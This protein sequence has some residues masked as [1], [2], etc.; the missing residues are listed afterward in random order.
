LAAGVQGLSPV[1]AAAVMSE[2]PDWGCVPLPGDP[3]HGTITIGGVQYPCEVLNVTGVAPQRILG[4]PSQ[5]GRRSRD[6][7]RFPARGLHGSTHKNRSSEGEVKKPK[8]ENS[9]EDEERLRQEEALNQEKA[10]CMAMYWRVFGW[11]GTWEF[12]M[13]IGN[14][15]V[16]IHREI[17]LV[18]AQKRWAHNVGDPG[19]LPGAMVELDAQMRRLQARLSWLHSLRQARADYFQDGACQKIMRQS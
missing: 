14:A 10:R 7:D 13:E 19:N 3:N 17:S 18:H 9:R 5:T 12:G 15:E 6:L 16:K 2:G 11:L 1:P 4:L 8:D